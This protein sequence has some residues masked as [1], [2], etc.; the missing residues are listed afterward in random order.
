MARPGPA[1]LSGRQVGKGR[2]TR[3]N[4]PPE[5]GRGITGRGGERRKVHKARDIVWQLGGKTGLPLLGSP[6]SSGLAGRGQPATS[7][8]RSG[9]ARRP[10]REVCVEG[11]HKGLSPSFSAG[12]QW[13]FFFS[14]IFH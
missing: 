3:G 5:R 10:R 1:S 11:A 4:G 14:S 9:A 7:T 2:G 12:V 13:S 8:G 6:S